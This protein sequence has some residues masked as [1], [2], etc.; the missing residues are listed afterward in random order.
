MVNLYQKQ[1][2][3]EISADIGNYNSVH[4]NICNC[5]KNSML[6][7][8]FMFSQC[9]KKHGYPNEVQAV[10]KFLVDIVITYDF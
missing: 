3:N 2:T 9:A 5:L 1:T 7:S 10:L 8:F 4:I 6:L